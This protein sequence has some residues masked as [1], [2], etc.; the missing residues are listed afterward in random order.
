[1]RKDAVSQSGTLCTN[2]KPVD[3]TMR[4]PRLSPGRY[5]V[6]GWNTLE[7]RVCATLEAERS[8]E[9]FLQVHVPPFVAD[10]ALA[11]RRQ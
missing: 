11:I 6:I 8:S 9:P 1:L 2:A 7:G 5:R 10:L 3:L 4:I